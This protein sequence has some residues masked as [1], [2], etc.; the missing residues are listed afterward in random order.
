MSFRP[1]W[2][3]WVL[4]F[5]LGALLGFANILV[6]VFLFYLFCRA[7]L[8]ASRSRDTINPPDFVTTYSVF[9]VFI[10]K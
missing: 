3:F 2:L 4:A 6:L 7:I 9:R 10:F 5:G 1:T 8:Y